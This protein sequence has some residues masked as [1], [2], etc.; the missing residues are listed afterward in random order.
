ME[1]D[2]LPALQLVRENVFLLDESVD[3]VNHILVQLL[4]ELIPEDQLLQYAMLRRFHRA[5]EAFQRAVAAALLLRLVRRP[6]DHPVWVGMRIR[7]MEE[8]E[9]EVTSEGAEEAIPWEEVGP[10]S[11]AMLVCRHNIVQLLL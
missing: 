11:V 1:K 2:P 9:E 4:T 6:Q 10:A 5:K 7:S 8:A 3:Y